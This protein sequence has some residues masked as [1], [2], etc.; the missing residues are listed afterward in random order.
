M[1]GT[2]KEENL[3]KIEP[4]EENAGEQLRPAQSAPAPDRKKMAALIAGRKS[5]L[6]TIKP[7]IPLKTYHAL[8]EKLAAEAT[9]LET[10]LEAKEQQVRKESREQALPKVFFEQ[11]F[12]KPKNI[13]IA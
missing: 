13:R 11:K 7:H 4:K 2:N 1:P 5:K 9:L 12:L 6:E 3:K 10:R 8:Q